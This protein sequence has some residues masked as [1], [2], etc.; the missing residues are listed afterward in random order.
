MG[1][2]LGYRMWDT[3]SARF[4]RLVA[5]QPKGCWIWTGDINHNGYGRLQYN[6]ERKMAHRVSLELHLGHALPADQMV[7]HKCDNP[8]CVNPEHLFVGDQ[9]DN[10]GD[11]AAKMRHAYGEQVPNATLRAKDVKEMRR[12]YAS[13]KCTQQELADRYGVS[14]GH[15]GLIVQRKRWPYT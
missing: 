3:L 10:M 12:L 5:K 15:V 14:R 11:C 9:T 8:R 2:Q 4:D 1:W 7:C 13:G 6:Y